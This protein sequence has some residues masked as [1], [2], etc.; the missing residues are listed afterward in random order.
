MV[1]VGA[2]RTSDATYESEKVLMCVRG[3]VPIFC[4][5]WSFGV[6]LVVSA[7]RGDGSGDERAFSDLAMTTTIRGSNQPCAQESEHLKIGYW[8][9]LATEP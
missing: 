4:R 2:K 8:R 3:I 9:L 1:G 7:R 6:R 5:A